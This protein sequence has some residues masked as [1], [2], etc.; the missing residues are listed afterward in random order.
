MS[1][2]KVY[3]FYINPPLLHLII[4]IAFLGG[5]EKIIKIKSRIFF[6]E[7]LVTFAGGN[8]DSKIERAKTKRDIIIL[9]S[10]S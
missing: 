10:H 5:A 6:V 8:W 1:L 2:L 4:N 3:W 7:L 9:L